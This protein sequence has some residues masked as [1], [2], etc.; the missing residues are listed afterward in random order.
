MRLPPDIEAACLALAD[1]ATVRAARLPRPE[2]RD[3]KEFLGQVID[4][5][6][7]QGFRV[8]HTFNS[9][10]SE[11]GFMDLVIAKPG[12]VLVSELKVGGNTTTA[13]QDWWLD[14]FRSVGLPAFEWRP[15]D[16]DQI[17]K[18]LTEGGR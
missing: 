13:D 3:E 11:K 5:A 18:E 4:L 1:P 6:K 17:V 9:R 10:R 16:W 8:Y 15:S 2:P 14:V 7:G 12:R